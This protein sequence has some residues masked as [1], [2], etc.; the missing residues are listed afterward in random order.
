MNIQDIVAKLENKIAEYERILNP[1]HSSIQKCNWIVEIGPYTAATDE[2]GKVVL[3]NRSYPVQYTEE[4]AKHIAS[5]KYSDLNGSPVNAQ[6]IHWKDWY[7]KEFDDAVETLAMLKESH[8][9]N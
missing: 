8:G 6:V 5:A 3:A 7:Q 4:A 1:E 9:L 2:N